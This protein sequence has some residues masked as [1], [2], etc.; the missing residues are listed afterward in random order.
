MIPELT[1]NKGFSTN[2]PCVFH[3]KNQSIESH[4]H[5]G[6]I[7][8]AIVLGGTGLVGGGGLGLLE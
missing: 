2:S 6:I 5:I 7:H 1:Q 3:R 8:Y 4:L